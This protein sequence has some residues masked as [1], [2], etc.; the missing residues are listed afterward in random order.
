MKVLFFKEGVPL[1]KRLFDLLLTIPGFILLLPL[2]LLIALA[3]LILDGAPVI[4]WQE[5]PGYHGRIFKVVK[6]RTMKDLRDGN[7]NLLADEERVSRLGW[8]LRSTSLDELPNILNVILGEMSLVG[9]RPLLVQYLARYSPEQ[10]RRHLVLPGMT[11]WAQ[12]HGRNALSWEEKF[13]LDVWY[14]DHWS[15]ALDAKILLLTIWKVLKREGISPMEQ[16]TTGEFMG[17]EKTR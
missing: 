9:P 4:F 12:I 15:L 6:F 14:V 13:T 1:R 8:F 7:N 3:I 16:M 5:R 11:G 10:A 17:N 2:L